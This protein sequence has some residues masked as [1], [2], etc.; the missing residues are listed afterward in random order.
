LLID[1]IP[2]ID[3]TR[4]DNAKRCEKHRVRRGGPAALYLGD[5]AHIAFEFRWTES[6]RAEMRF[7]ANRALPH[8]HLTLKGTGIRAGSLKLD[9]RALY[10]G[11][12]LVIGW[13]RPLLTPCSREHRVDYVGHNCEQ[14]G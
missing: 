10:R 12:C 14:R 2:V 7:K 4:P 13:R 3:K 9:P 11:L 8:G 6:Q 5:G 1:A